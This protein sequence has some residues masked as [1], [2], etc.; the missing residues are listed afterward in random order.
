MKTF[1]Q[2]KDL[3]GKSILNN[4]PSEFQY[5]LNNEIEKSEKIEILFGHKKVR[6][7]IGKQKNQNGELI[8]LTIEEKYIN[9]SSLFRE[10]SI[11]GLLTLDN[12]ITFRNNISLNQNEYVQDLIHNLTSLNTYNVQE[13]ESLIPP[14]VLTKNINTQKET[15]KNI[16]NEKPNIT[17]N[18]LLKLIKYNYAMKVE[19]SVFEKT[20]MQNPT[21]QKLEYSVRET[22]LSILQIFIEEFEEKKIVVSIDTNEKRIHIDFEILFVSLFYIFENA[23]KYCCPYS[24]FKILFK[25]EQNKYLVIFDMLSLRI[26]DFEVP[27]LCQKKFR[28]KSAI[29][30]TSEGKGIG[31]SRVLKTLKLNNAELEIIPRVS[32]FSK[33][34]DNSSYE[35]NQFILK[36]DSNRLF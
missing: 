5:L 24:K 9:S 18:T 15:I 26:E 7:R 1:Y 11:M 3:D 4:F 35:H 28:A 22:I 27:K 29:E 31:M 14:K 12:V 8:I 20:V 30:L 13:L 32:D 34:K 19:F 36:F 17:T 2:I 25:E 21:V 33:T 16:V 6:A 10:L 23:V